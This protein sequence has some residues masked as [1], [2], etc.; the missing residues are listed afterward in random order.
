MK[1]L[2]ILWVFVA[3][4]WGGCDDFLTSRDNTQVLEKTLF[5]DREG[6]EDALYGIYSGLAK[7]ELYG[8]YVPCR[9]DLLAQFYKPGN[10]ALYDVLHY[11][12]LKPAGRE[13]CN[14]IWKTMYRS[15]SDINSFLANLDAY[16]G[17]SLMFGDLYRGEALGLRAYL[18]FD[19]LRMYAPV[20]LG[21]RGIPYIT[22]FGSSVTSFST[23]KE[24]YNLII[25]DLLE[26]EKLLR[27]DD[28]L[29]MLPRV[30]SH[31]FVICRNREVHFNWYAVQATLA[32]VYY[33]RGEPGDLE[34]AGEYAR[35][36]IDSEKFPLI[37]DPKDARFVV[38]GVVAETEA[39]WGLSNKNLYDPMAECFLTTSDYSAYKP[40]DSDMSL[41]ESKAGN[42]WRKE[43]LIA[44]PGTGGSTR[45]VKI[46]D[47][48]EAGI[49]SLMPAGV[50]GVNQIR[51][52][53]MYLIAAEAALESHPETARKYLEDLVSSRGLERFEG[54]LTLENIDK[55][56]RRELAQE[57]QVWFR[58]KHRHPETVEAVDRNV[59]TMTEE[60]WQLL[61]PDDEFEFRE[62]FTM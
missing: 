52:T 4:L 40:S 54:E 28:T 39:V 58:M 17:E 1:R 59:I 47:P 15:I 16:E 55:E 51:V 48:V 21:E 49:S 19:L 22:R 7:P 36:V 50:E 12:F 57:G 33:M 37:S 45:W 13:V 2:T 62:D 8:F 34:K 3:L 35:A 26:A 53:E 56:W 46:I 41:Y 24:C 20:K 43:W 11:D 61:I 23:V 44:P 42:D 10:T 38:A 32:R 31:E 29:L 18:H 30:R 60:M 6:V 14:S 5:A 9:M 27:Q 25:D